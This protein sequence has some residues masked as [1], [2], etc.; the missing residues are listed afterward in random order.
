MY[1]KHPKGAQALF[2]KKWLDICRLMRYFIG[3]TKSEMLKEISILHETLKDCVLSP[4]DRVAIRN[5]IGDLQDR[6]ALL[7]FQES[8]DIDY[9]YHD[10]YDM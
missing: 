9:G 10:Q 6:V 7:D 1:T 4:A 3:M 5:E 2:V 8:E